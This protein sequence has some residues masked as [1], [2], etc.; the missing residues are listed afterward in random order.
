MRALI[1][2]L[3]AAERAAVCDFDARRYRLAYG[4]ADYVLMPLDLDPC[5][6]PCKI[7]QRYGALPIACDA[8]AIH[9]CVAHLEPA[10]NRGTG[11]LFKHCD[12]SGFL[13][14]ID[15]AMAFYRQPPAFRSSQVQRIMTDSLLRFDAGESA[16]QIVDLYARVLDRSLAPLNDGAGMA[17]AARIAA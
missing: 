6:L 2:R 11:F 7:G 10:A 4:G 15:T 5:A 3:Q 8:G 16:Q 13:W 1:G 14:A 17:A 12:A 9:D